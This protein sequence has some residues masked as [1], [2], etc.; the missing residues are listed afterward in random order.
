MQMKLTTLRGATVATI[1]TAIL[2]TASLCSI[3]F[4]QTSNAS[5]SNVIY[6]QK[7]KGETAVAQISLREGN[8]FTDISAQGFRTIA[9]VKQLCVSVRESDPDE[10]DT[11]FQGCGPAQRLSI[12]LGTATFGGTITG[13]DF[14]TGEEK[15]VTVNA[16]LTATGKAET[17]KFSTHTNNRNI[18]EVFHSYGTIRPASGSLNIAG[19][20]TFS[21]DDAF[22]IISKFAVGTIQVTKN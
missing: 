18:N 12:G 11:V 8:V 3:I 4:I 5:A 13:F 19:G 21:A 17:S 15:T 16:E 14:T 6:K 2:V 10:S 7:I 1:F 22:G 20:I 9:G